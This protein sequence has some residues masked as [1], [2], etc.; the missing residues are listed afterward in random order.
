MALQTPPALPA[1][2]KMSENKSS[3]FESD[4]EKILLQQKFTDF[5]I[6]LEEG[7]LRC[8]KIILASRCLFFKGMLSSN[9]KESLKG[10]NCIKFRY[11]F[12]GNSFF[13]H[14]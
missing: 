9:F 6:L 11:I 3:E 13:F 2:D 12:N 5:T 4:I 14:I 10:T 7:Q 8:H 1:L